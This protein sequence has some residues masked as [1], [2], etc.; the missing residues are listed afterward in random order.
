MFGAAA[1][2]AALAVGLSVAQETS[3]RALR[4]VMAEVSVSLYYKHVRNPLILSVSAPYVPPEQPRMFTRLPP[5]RRLIETPLGIL[6]TGLLSMRMK[7]AHNS[8]RY[9]VTWARWPRGALTRLPPDPRGPADRCAE[10]APGGGSPCCVL[11]PRALRVFRGPHPVLRARGG[12]RRGH[13]D[14]RPSYRRPFGRHPFPHQ[15]ILP[16]VDYHRHSCASRAA[17]PTPCRVPRAPRPSPLAAW[18][19]TRPTGPSPRT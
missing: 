6:R 13:R 17:P 2:C 3:A 1:L 11:Q 9:I 14:P 7:I 19:S 18:S 5:G 12:P 4:D 8:R 15:V 10:G 16:P